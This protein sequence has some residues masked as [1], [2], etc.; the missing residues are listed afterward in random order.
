MKDQ[1]FLTMGDKWPSPWVARTEFPKFS[2]GLYSERYMANLDCQGKG[3]EGRIRCGRKILYPTKN[4]LIWMMSRSSAIPDKKH[5][6]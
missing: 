3:I 5:N 6:E 2:G 4:A 1:S